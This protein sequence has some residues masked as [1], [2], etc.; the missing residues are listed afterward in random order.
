[1]VDLQPVVSPAGAPAPKAPWQ[2]K[3]MWMSALG[4]L[5]PLVYPPAAIW[6]AANP[7]IYSA[8]LSGVFAVLRLVSRGKVTFTD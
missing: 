1:M 3:T 6:I 8:A 4:V 2:S 5:A 7:V